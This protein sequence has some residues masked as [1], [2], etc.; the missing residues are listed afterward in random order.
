KHNISMPAHTHDIVIQP[1]VHVVTLPNHAHGIQHGIFEYG[2]LPTAVT[3]EV[4][5]TELEHTEI[6]GEGID[7]VPYLQKDAKGNVVRGRYAEI[8]IKP[9]DLARINATVT[10]RLFIQSHIGTVV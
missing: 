3:I 10:S 8:V 9:N 6:N 5:G 1:H 2:T 4:D 7:L